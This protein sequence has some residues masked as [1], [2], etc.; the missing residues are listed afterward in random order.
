M[1]RLGKLTF[2]YIR[3]SWSSRTLAFLVIMVLLTGF[4]LWGVP[5][6][7]DGEQRVFDRISLSIVDDD[8][9]LISQILIEQLS[10]IG[11]IDAIFLDTLTRAQSRLA[12]NEILLVIV[13]PAGFYDQTSHGSERSPLKVLINERMPAETAI[14]VRFL[15]NLADSI[16]AVQSAY[17]AFG[18]QVRPLYDNE[19]SYYR[20]MDATFI[21]LF[22]KMLGRKSFITI[23]GEFQLHTVSFVISALLCLLTLLTALMNLLQVQQDRRNNLP[24]RLHAAGITWWQLLLARQ[25]A[26]AVWLAAGFAP[27]LSGLFLFDRQMNRIP[28]IGAVVLLYWVGSALGQ[29]W[30]QA[31]TIGEAKVMGA[32]LILFVMLLLGGCIYPLAL[33]PDRLQLFSRLSPAYWAFSMIYGAYNG[34][35]PTGISWLA[36]AIMIGTSVFLVWLSCLQQPLRRNRESGKTFI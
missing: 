32:W 1:T 6:M 28:V 9:S 35:S 4:V 14:F 20:Q 18:E 10:D 33:L 13:I 11:M 2:F 7:N 27:L 34:H 3:E 36:W 29:A 17:Y 31:G 5:A 22:L 21:Q 15:N 12:A 30:A 8:R 16:V 19:Q 24:D 23:T 26:G 25:L